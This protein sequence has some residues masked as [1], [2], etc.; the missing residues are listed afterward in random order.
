MDIGPVEVPIGTLYESRD[1]A[2][3][4]HRMT[5]AGIA[6]TESSGCAAICLNG[7]YID[8]FDSGFR[9][10]YTGSSGAETGMRLNAGQTN[11]LNMDQKWTDGNKALRTSMKNNWPVRVLRGPKCDAQWAPA[12]TGYR[13]DGLYMIR[14]CWVQ[15]G[16]TGVKIIRFAM[17]RLH[18]QGPLFVN[19]ETISPPD[20]A[21]DEEYQG[22]W[23]ILDDDDE[24]QRP[25]KAHEPFDT[26]DPK[27]IYIKPKA[28]LVRPRD[29][30]SD[31]EAEQRRQ[32]RAER[33]ARRPPKISRADTETTE[34]GDRE[35]AHSRRRRELDSDSDASSARDPARRRRRDQSRSPDRPAARIRKLDK[36]ARA[37]QF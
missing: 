14:R 17:E 3:P 31:M 1:A 33:R 37:R 12:T 10:I 5:Q 20:Y 13:Y 21:D 29:R 8:D 16:A 28:A 2:F 23:P 35:V 22:E 27:D 15:R 32:R 26:I 4:I 36:F 18:D 6:G 24:V 34:D 19:E 11:N 7:G 9:I 25:I 30:L